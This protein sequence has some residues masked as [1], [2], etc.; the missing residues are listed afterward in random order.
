MEETEEEERKMILDANNVPMDNFCQSP[1]TVNTQ[2]ENVNA[3]LTSERLN[4]LDVLAETLKVLTIDS[5]INDSAYYDSDENDAE[6]YPK[7]DPL[8]ATRTSDRKKRKVTDTATT[9][10]NYLQKLLTNWT[11]P[12]IILPIDLRLLDGVAAV[13]GTMHVRHT[14]TSKVIVTDAAP[15][16]AR[17]FC[18]P[19]YVSRTGRYGTTSRVGNTSI[20]SPKLNS[21]DLIGSGN[22]ISPTRTGSQDIGRPKGP[23]GLVEVKNDQIIN[24]SINGNLTKNGYPTTNFSK[25]IGQEL[26][27]NSSTN[28]YLRCRGN[29]TRNSV[30]TESPDFMDL[31][32]LAVHA[33]YE[34]RL[35]GAPATIFGRPTDGLSWSAPSHVFGEATAVGVSGTRSEQNY[36]SKTDFETRKRTQDLSGKIFL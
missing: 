23:P 25:V 36:S 32:I 2:V 10:R 13:R 33:S 11:P 22:T 15:S 16:G 6:G 27:H 17:I 19:G 28:I 24:T 30:G 31:G 5:T 20:S 1:V 7:S 26:S 8:V 4:N 35:F 29:L 14:P 3:I 34:L 18:T 9:S 21:P 12:I